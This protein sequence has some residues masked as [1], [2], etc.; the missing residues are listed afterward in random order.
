MKNFRV[1]DPRNHE[2]FILSPSIVVLKCCKH[3]K[4]RALRNQIKTRTNQAKRKE[5]YG[6]LNASN[7]WW[8][9][10]VEYMSGPESRLS[11]S[12]QQIY[13]TLRIYISLVKDNNPLRNMTLSMVACHAKAI[14]CPE[15]IQQQSS[16]KT[17]WRSLPWT[18]LVD[19]GLFLR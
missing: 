9:S 15:F 16:T 14:I 17:P 13:M 12:H 10:D 18:Q 5:E 1:I 2:D 3:R 19:T 11:L 4:S 7:I 8:I 6:T